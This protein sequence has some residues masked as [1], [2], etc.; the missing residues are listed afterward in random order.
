MFLSLCLCSSKRYQNILVTKLKDFGDNLNLSQ[1]NIE[2]KNIL[3]Y[4]IRG[5]PEYHQKELIS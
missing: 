1:N 5:T 4:I 3:S 2:E